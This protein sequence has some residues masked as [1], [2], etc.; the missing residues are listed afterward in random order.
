MIPLSYPCQ[1]CQVAGKLSS[2]RFHEY[3]E[4]C[5]VSYNVCCEMILKCKEFSLIY[6][7][8]INSIT[9]KVG[10]TFL[11]EVTIRNLIFLGIYFQSDF[12]HLSMFMCLKSLIKSALPT[13]QRN[14]NMSIR[15]VLSKYA[16]SNIQMLQ[17][18]SRISKGNKAIKLWISLKH[19]TLS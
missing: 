5:K 10:T 12:N 18:F 19:I 14:Q 11:S 3:L 2:I 9:T 8:Y 7:S 4:I 1:Q 15:N 17:I 16:K 6:L 13:T